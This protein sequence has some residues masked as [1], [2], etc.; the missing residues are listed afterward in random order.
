[1]YNF[2][3]ITGLKLPPPLF[4]PQGALGGG[5]SRNLKGKIEIIDIRTNENSRFFWY[6]IQLNLSLPVLGLYKGGKGGERGEGYLKNQ[7]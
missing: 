4:H 1:M 2:C 6:M 3:V 5:S 7:K